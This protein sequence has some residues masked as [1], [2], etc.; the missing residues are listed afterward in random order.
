MTGND[1]REGD[2][3]EIL[4]DP[5]NFLH[6]IDVPGGRAVFHHADARLLREASFLDGRSGI[7]STAPAP[8]PLRELVASTAE[9]PATTNR[10]L[11]NVS[12]CGSTHLARL[13]DV[14]G[15]SLVLKEPQCLNDIAAWK[16]STAREG[17]PLTCLRPLLKLANST[18]GRSFE[19]GEAVAVKLACQGNVLVDALAESGADVRPLFITSGRTDFLRAIFRG[20]VNR[21]RYIAKIVWNLATDVVDGD[22][23]LLEAVGAG[24]DPNRKAANLALL[25]QSFQVGA[26]D[27]A[28]KAGDWD[29]GHVVD[30]QDII[31]RPEEAALKAAKAL[32]LDINGQ[33][34]R[35]NVERLANR[36]SK[37]PTEPF[38]SDRQREADDRLHF[39]YRH[40]FDDA[41]KWAESRLG[42][43]RKVGS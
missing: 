37:L 5:S 33:D 41:L 1:R 43:E 32:D 10:L 20:G 19:P 31:Q 3:A 29:E 8:A 13:L 28:A 2:P 7:A 40:A 24:S 23:M 42:A 9:Q 21:M 27:R 15:Q 22:A 6:T 26:F 11:F 14:P 36:Y 30:Y 25:A 12:F 35:D 38:S 39:E 18:L 34:I 16:V 4:G 17:R